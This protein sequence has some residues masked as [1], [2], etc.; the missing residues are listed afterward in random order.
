V[1]RKLNSAVAEGIAA[2]STPKGLLS[3]Y[4]PVLFGQN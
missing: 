4:F 3:K 2:I 1:K